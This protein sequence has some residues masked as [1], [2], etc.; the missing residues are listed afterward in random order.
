MD[1]L[2]RWCELFAALDIKAG[3]LHP[4]GSELRATGA[5]PE[6]ILECNIRSLEKQS[7][8]D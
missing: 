8:F 2:K 7:D 1:D 3:V 4:G 6:M 5:D